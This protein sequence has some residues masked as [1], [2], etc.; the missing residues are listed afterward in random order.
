MFREQPP[1]AGA[2][3]VKICGTTNL[4]DAQH[5][6]AAGADA[7]GFIFAP[8][9]RRVSVEQA[10]RMT[11]EVPASILC[12]GVFTEGSATDIRDAVHGAGLHAV[13]LHLPYDA[14]LIATLHAARVQ[15]VQVVKVESDTGLLKSDAAAAERL[16]EELTTALSDDRLWAVLLDASFA[17]VSGGL[18]RSF[19]WDTV[20]PLLQAARRRATAEHSA[21][22]TTGPHVLL[23]G[24]LHAG[25]VAEAMRALEPWGVDVVSGVE[26]APGRKDPEQLHGF[27]QAAQRGVPGR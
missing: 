15:L 16:T 26:A 13:Q 25:N 12:V 5:S 19:G 17:G 9:K 20:R 2:P 21:R 10:A 27:V 18:G 24:G 3:F 7:L 1:A 4:Q 23:A 22:G 6:I 8:S 11:R 14:A